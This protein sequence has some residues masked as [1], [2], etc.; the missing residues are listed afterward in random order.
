MVCVQDLIVAR[1]NLSGT[2][3]G[4]SPDGHYLLSPLPFSIGSPETTLFQFGFNPY[5]RKEKKTHNE[6]EIHPFNYN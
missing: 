3:E 6:G 5:Q 1:S 4:D 2:W